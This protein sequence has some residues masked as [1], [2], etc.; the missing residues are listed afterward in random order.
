MLHAATAIGALLNSGGELARSTRWRRH[1]RVGSSRRWRLVVGGVLP[2]IAIAVPSVWQV[3]PSVAQLG[4][5]DCHTMLVAL[6]DLHEVVPVNLARGTV[7]SPIDVGDLVQG[8]AVAPDART[9]YA[10]SDT[11]VTPI[12]LADGTLGTPIA[13]GTESGG[14]Q[15]RTPAIS[16]D[17]RILAISRADGIVLVDLATGTA[18]PLIPGPSVNIAQT[19]FTPDGTRLLV[20]ATGNRIYPLDVA[21]ETFGPRSA[22]ASIRSRWPSRQMV[23][24]PTSG[25]ASAALSARST[26]PLISPAPKSRSAAECPWSPPPQMG[27]RPS[28]SSYHRV[29]PVGR[30]PPIPSAPRSTSTEWHGGQRLAPTAS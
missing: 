19:A 9:A 11:T 21:T 22:L 29:T 30:S 17:G 8:L 7:G 26:W 3:P 5:I 25:T 12:D 1:G 10:V 6:P 18:G 27:G 28:S 2:L 24:A 15:A 13:V 16:P 4:P 14:S 23:L 20:G